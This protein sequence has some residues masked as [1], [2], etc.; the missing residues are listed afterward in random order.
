MKNNSVIKIKKII[1]EE[2]K[3]LLDL[4]EN[5]PFL[6]EEKQYFNYYAQQFCDE[7]TDSTNE[8]EVTEYPSLE[9]QS[10]L[11]NNQS[12]SQNEIEYTKSSKSKEQSRMLTSLNINFDNVFPEDDDD[13]KVRRAK[14]NKIEIP[15]DSPEYETIKKASKMSTDSQASQDKK[16]EQWLISRLVVML[17]NKIK[18][19]IFQKYDSEFFGLDNN[20]INLNEIKQKDDGRITY[21]NKYD[22]RTVTFLT[23][24]YLTQDI[25]AS[26]NFFDLA[27]TK[28]KECQDNL[29][30]FFKWSN[31]SFKQIVDKFLQNCEQ[32]Y[33]PSIYQR[34]LNEL[35]DN[36]KK[37]FFN[38]M[39]MKSIFWLIQLID[40]YLKFFG[41]SLFSNFI[42]K[43]KTGLDTMIKDFQDTH[44]DAKKGGEVL[45]ERIKN[46]YLMGSLNIDFMGHSLGTV[47]V[48]Y[49]L[50]N[51]SIP[52]RHLMLFGGAATITEIE[53]SQ[54][55]FQKCYNFYS[56]NDEVVKKFL[57]QAKL[58]G[59][60]DFIG[61]KSFGQRKDKFF[62]LN[63]QIGHVTYILKFQKYYDHAMVEFKPSN[64]IDLIEN[65]V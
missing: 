50:K 63:T 43:L 20:I 61:A 40:K 3:D 31:S 18:Y 28:N 39:I 60:Q 59:N 19:F 12:Y 15:Q 51:L 24:G 35:L 5:F 37:E 36:C 57:T 10:Y 13:V 34:Y 7:Y 17:L 32:G 65:Q 45:A 48:A 54:E 23:S 62:N 52:A 26:L 2:E 29:F 64:S 16:L 1:T 42:S 33:E 21:K 53:D 22:L 30:I 38:Q 56:D 4:Y 46:Q 6:E 11:S 8:D 25:N 58:I 49:A 55:K 27:N 47:V 41:T 9:S 44:Q 14:S